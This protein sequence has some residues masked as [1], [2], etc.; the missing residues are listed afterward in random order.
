MGQYHY[1]VNLDK[2]EYLNPHDLGFG[3]KLWEQIPWEYSP[4]TVLGL[5]LAVSNGRG[6]GDFSYRYGDNK[7]LSD[8]AEKFIG[9]WGGDRIA[10]IGDYAEPGDLAP[11]LVADSIYALCHE[12]GEAGV[13][14][15]WL[16]E[17]FPD[18]ATPFT[19]ADLFTNL[20][21]LA[22]EVMTEIF[23]VTY[24]GTGWLTLKTPTEID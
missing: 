12:P 22:R 23:G 2:R 4:M 17:R 18:R 13:Q 8:Q 3:L 5:L 19:Q 9:R 1:V 24:S 20:S 14:V 15:T 10:I 11:E 6:G 21:P 16:N 7:D